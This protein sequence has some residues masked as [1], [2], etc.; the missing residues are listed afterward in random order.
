MV[1]RNKDTVRSSPNPIL[2]FL[3]VGPI[4]LPRVES[5]PLRREAQPSP[6]Q[7]VGRGS[8]AEYVSYPRPSDRQTAVYE[9]HTWGRE[10]L[11]VAALRGVARLL[12]EYMELRYRALLFQRNLRRSN[13]TISGRAP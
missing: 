2:A 5:I 11:S 12:D 13:D 3:S 8:E 7:V 6:L 4:S 10:Y 1:L 9:D